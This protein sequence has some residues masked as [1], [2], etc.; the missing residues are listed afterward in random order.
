MFPLHHLTVFCY[1]T[2]VRFP[3]MR[4]RR[5]RLIG[6]KL[7]KLPRFSESANSKNAAND[8]GLRQPLSVTTQQ[9]ALSTNHEKS[10]LNLTTSKSDV[11]EEMS[12]E[13]NE[14]NLV[15]EIWKNRLNATVKNSAS[16]AVGREEDTPVLNQN[17]ISFLD[18]PGRWTCRSK[19]EHQQNRRISLRG[20]K[21][22][23]VLQNMK[24]AA[25][26]FVVAIVY[27]IALIPAM[28]MAIGVIGMYLPIFY[29]Y[30]VN[31]AINPIIY[32]FMNPTFREDVQNFFTA[33][34]R[35]FHKVH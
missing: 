5:T 35:S 20:F 7:R 31:N 2:L 16:T 3:Q 22:N 30:Y 29:M 9:S 12:N 4:E 8:G 14:Q 34:F 11:A 10:G 18:K 1:K 6:S 27:I 32:C 25:T 28:L 13:R 19:Q 21:G 24:T 15:S 26:L 23:F 33:R 17:R